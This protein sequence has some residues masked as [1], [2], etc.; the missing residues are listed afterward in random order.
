MFKQISKIAGISFASTLALAVTANN[1]YAFDF[2]FQFSD[3]TNTATGTILGLTE[4][5]STPSSVTA[6]S[7]SLGITD[8]NFTTPVSFTSGAANTFTVLSGEI[9]SDDYVAEADNGSGD[10]IFFDGDRSEG[11]WIRP[12]FLGNASNIGSETI[13]YTP[14][15]P[16]S[17]PFGVSTDLSLIILGGLYGASRLRKKFVASK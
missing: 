9:I 10:L 3:G 4:G 17:V 5:T 14:L 7:P 11:S 6:S 1:V 13:T 8:V 15:S 2:S 12:Y 16:T